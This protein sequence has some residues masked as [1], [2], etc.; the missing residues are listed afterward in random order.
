MMNRFLIMFAI[1]TMICAITATADTADQV[2][3]SVWVKQVG[4][5]VNETSYSFGYMQFD[6]EKSTDTTRFKLTNS[7]NY[8]ENI[9]VAAETPNWTLGTTASVDQMVLSIK[10]VG[11][12][13]TDWEP[14]ADADNDLMVYD[15]AANSNITFGLKVHS[16]TSAT[17]FDRQWITINLSAISM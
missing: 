12:N 3:I 4:I 16:P 5:E 9:Y 10:T 13:F 14:I 11:G 17:I 7:G 1:L 8:N 2:V 6:A 15:L